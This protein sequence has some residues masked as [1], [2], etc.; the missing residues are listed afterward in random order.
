MCIYIQWSRALKTHSFKFKLT[1]CFKF[2]TK[3]TRTHVGFFFFC[4]L[5]CFCSVKPHFCLGEKVTQAVLVPSHFVLRAASTVF[6][7]NGRC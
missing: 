6:V 4:F 7:V 3:V 1:F 5:L 2:K